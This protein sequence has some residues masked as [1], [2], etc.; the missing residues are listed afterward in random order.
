MTRC[1]SFLGAIFCAALVGALTQGSARAETYPSHA[2][3]LLVPFAA[4]GPT[5]VTGRI[6]ADVLSRRLGQPVVVENFGGAGGNVGA[7]RAAHAPPD[8][9]TL[10]FTNIS[11]A[12]SPAL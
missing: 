6:L 1:F 10:L 4:G 8:G 9:Y 3:K 5:D 12:I 7:E 2:I 11:M